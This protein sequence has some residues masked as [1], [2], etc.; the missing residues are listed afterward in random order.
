[1]KTRSIHVLLIEDS[2]MQRQ[3]VANSLKTSTRAT[4]K[5]SCAATLHEGIQAMTQSPADVVLLDLMLPDS[6]EDKT[7]ARFQEKHPAAAVVVL[8]STDDDSLGQRLVEAGAQDYLVKSEVNTRTLIRAIIYA[9]ERRRNE[10][11]RLRLSRELDASIEKIHTLHG[12]LP[13][14]SYCKNV[15]EDTGYWSKIEAYIS[16]NTGAVFT[17]GICPQC[18]E[19][20]KKEIV[21]ANCKAA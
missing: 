7:L 8:T 15:R 21:A 2:K 4:F 18:F 16:S 14:C 20:V 11:E 5:V 10:A 1:M 19:K 17:H 9:F 13:I 6:L 3:F 12:L